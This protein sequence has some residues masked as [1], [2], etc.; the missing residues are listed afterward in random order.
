MPTSEDKA[1]GD[2]VRLCWTGGWDSTFRLL[3]ALIIERTP[4]Q[5][6]YVINPVRASH[7]HEMRAMERIRAEVVARFPFTAE[8]LQPTRTTD[9]GDI[10]PDPEITKS[11]NRLA[12]K[13]HLGT[14]YEWLARF[15][16]QTQFCDLELAVHRDDKAHGFLQDWVRAEKTT[17]TTAYVLKPEALETDLRI[18]KFFRFPLFDYT[19]LRMRDEAAAHGFDMLLNLT[20]FC[21]SP[22]PDGRP[23]GACAGCVYTRDEGL[24]ERVPPPSFPRRIFL[25][26]SKRIPWRLKRTIKR[27]RGS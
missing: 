4:V 7:S 27:L 19:K 5:P 15:A 14:Q 13:S 12:D 20:W 24:G 3:Q 1:R 10:L 2:A 23:C 6:L 21:H 8:L 9:F 25:E 18:F 22:R 16:S 26:V 17:G 11:F